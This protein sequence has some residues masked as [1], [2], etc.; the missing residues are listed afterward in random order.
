MF[1][2]FHGNILFLVVYF[3]SDIVKATTLFLI[4][5]ACM[6][7][8]YF[9]IILCSICLYKQQI[10]WYYLFTPKYNDLCL[11]IVIQISDIRCALGRNGSE[12]KLFLLNIQNPLPLAL[13]YI[14]DELYGLL[15]STKW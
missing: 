10:M 1:T 6:V 3:L 4:L 14:Q 9:L 2:F 5:N 15:F 11:L 12:G 7:Y 13:L 8:L